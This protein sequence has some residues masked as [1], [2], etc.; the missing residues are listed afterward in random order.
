MDISQDIPKLKTILY[1]NEV[2]IASFYIT[3]SNV[4]VNLTLPPDVYI[5]KTKHVFSIPLEGPSAVSLD[6]KDF[7]IESVAWIVKPCEVWKLKPVKCYETL[8][9]VPRMLKIFTVLTPKNLPNTKIVVTTYKNISSESYILDNPDTNRH[10]GVP[11]LWFLILPK[12][13]YLPGI[14]GAVGK[15]MGMHI[16]QNGPKLED[17]DK[18]QLEKL[19]NT[20]LILD[21]RHYYVKEL[22]FALDENGELK[23]EKYINLGTAKEIKIDDGAQILY[24]YPTNKPLQI[25]T[26]QWLILN[27]N[28]DRH[29][30][31]NSE[32][33]IQHDSVKLSPGQTIQFQYIIS[34]NPFDDN[35]KKEMMNTIKKLNIA[36]FHKLD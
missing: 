35:M 25:M 7:Y 14:L 11:G 22:G 24:I 15:P 13:N 34:K 28:G 32:I 8:G 2:A 17:L 9:K 4:M 21:D 23:D 18:K 3:L 10:R 26:N 27:K 20:K 5:N 36:D 1:E 33:N 19:G 16:L 12:L 31:F 29:K 30:L 6:N